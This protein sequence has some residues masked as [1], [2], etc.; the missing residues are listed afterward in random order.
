MRVKQ[1][2]D[3]VSLTIFAVELE[4]KHEILHKT[5]Q[6]EA[7]E[8]ILF[9]KSSHDFLFSVIIYIQLINNYIYEK[10]TCLTRSCSKNLEISVC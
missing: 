10:Y 1:E 6:N 7:P 2:S 4:I 5:I 8:N 9:N 3:R